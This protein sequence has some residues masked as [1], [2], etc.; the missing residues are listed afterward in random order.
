MGNSVGLN[1]RVE[2]EYET[3]E[4]DSILAYNCVSTEEDAPVL[5][6]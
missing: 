5:Y 4:A 3:N 2:V 6:R 1:E